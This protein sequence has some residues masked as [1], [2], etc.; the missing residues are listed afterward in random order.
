MLTVVPFGARVWQYMFGANCRASWTELPAMRTASANAQAQSC[1][2]P[3]TVLPRDDPA[4]DESKCKEGHRA[5]PSIRE[6]LCNL[7]AQEAQRVLGHPC[8]GVQL[9]LA[10]PSASVLLRTTPKAQQSTGKILQS[11]LSCLPLCRARSHASELRAVRA[12]PT[13]SH[14]SGAGP[15]DPRRVKKRKC[16]MGFFTLLALQ[17]QR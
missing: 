5:Q 10:F 7:H 17:G 6:L 15:V 4:D 8:R 2:A 16:Q 9:F 1:E 12:A 11:F 14:G 13:R 3:Y